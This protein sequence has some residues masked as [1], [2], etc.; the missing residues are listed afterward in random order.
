VCSTEPISLLRRNTPKREMGFPFGLRLWYGRARR[1]R[2]PE[3]CSMSGT[4]QG[5]LQWPRHSDTRRD[6]TPNVVAIGKYN[7][8]TTLLEKR[9]FQICAKQTET[10]PSAAC[11]HEA[12]ECYSPI[13]CQGTR[14]RHCVRQARGRIAVFLSLWTASGRPAC[15]MRL[16]ASI[17]T[18]QVF[19]AQDLKI[20]HID[21]AQKKNTR[22]IIVFLSFHLLRCLVDCRL[23][24]LSDTAVDP[25]FFEKSKVF[26]PVVRNFEANFLKIV[27]RPLN[28][29]LL[30]LVRLFMP[31]LTRNGG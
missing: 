31:N 10:P 24:F 14:H 21:P 9:N 8:T 29:D 15:P 5:G 20:Q 30:P 22:N 17:K 27:E 4:C 23:S 25:A 26:V 18:R 7:I 1:L 11:D 12:L 16:G 2:T 3:K 6:K 13:D 19:P 28:G